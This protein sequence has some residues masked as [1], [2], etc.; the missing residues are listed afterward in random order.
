LNRMNQVHFSIFHFPFARSFHRI[1][2]SRRPCATFRIMLVFFISDRLL[3]PAPKHHAGGPPSVGCQY[4]PSY[5]IHLE[6]V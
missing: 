3:A 6:A 5:P 4:I 2:Q 1:H